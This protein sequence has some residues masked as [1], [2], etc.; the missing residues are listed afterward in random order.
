MKAFQAE[1][2]TYIDDSK[3]TNVDATVKAMNAMTEPTVIL[4]GGKDKGYDY[5][6]LLSLT[7]KYF[8]PLKYT[9]PF[10]KYAPSVL[11]RIE[12]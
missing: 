3:G 6:P 11:S 9:L 7:S 2:K 4:L 5:M 8:S 10:S 12:K 1:R